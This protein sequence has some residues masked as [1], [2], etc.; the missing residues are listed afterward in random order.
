MGELYVKDIKVIFIFFPN[1]VF[2]IKDIMII[3][4]IVE[5]QIYSFDDSITISVKIKMIITSL[6]EKIQ[7]LD[8]NPI[9]IIV[10]LIEKPRTKLI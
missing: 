4:F 6:T 8:K 2:S 9:M 7:N 1:S 5:I 10:S 3:W